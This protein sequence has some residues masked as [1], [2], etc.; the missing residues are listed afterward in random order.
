[1]SGGYPLIREYLHPQEQRGGI[2][3]G[4]WECRPGGS[5]TGAV[6]PLRAF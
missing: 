4:P 6:G 5:Y 2:V 1:M 3:I